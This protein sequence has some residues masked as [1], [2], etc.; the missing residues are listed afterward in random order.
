MKKNLLFFF[1]G[2]ILTLLVWLGLYGLLSKNSQN[3]FLIKNSII[4]YQIHSILDKYLPTPEPKKT[5]T[6]ILKAFTSSYWDQFT[7]YFWPDEVVSFQTMVSGDF[8][9]IW[10]YIEES[11]GG[12]Y[13]KWVIPNSPAQ[14]W[15]LLP[16]DV[17]Q[18]VD[19]TQLFN[20]SAEEAIKKIRWPAGS[21][22]VLEIFSTLLG[23]KKTVALIRNNIELPIIT[24]TLI[25]NV[26][27]IE[28]TSFN[29]HSSDDMKQV[30]KKNT[31]K[32]N[33]ILLDLRNNGGGTLQ[34]AV[35]VASIFIPKG[36]IVVSVEG[37]TIE[38]YR[39]YGE[40]ITTLPLTI[41]VNGETASAAEILASALHTHLRSSLVGSQTYGKWS[42]QEIFD[43]SNGGQIK[44][45]TSHWRTAAG[46]FL[47]G[48]GITPDTIILPTAQEVTEW[49]DG[50]R[51][52]AL[53]MIKK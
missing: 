13:I 40:N 10:A 20:V 1:T 9:G 27:V 25:G 8:D 36:K 2:I 21:E 35:D 17:I 48:V 22:V 19:D 37:K 14:L 7:T 44:V 32:Y 31:G 50:Q 4:S 5:E 45:T 18:K 28:L 41:L 34:A 51:I 52:R 39:S 30:L 16:G 38:Q 23:V 46:D 3:F 24:D 6:A 29:D 42:V 33:H 26:L 11:A 12:I 15:G 49:K 43:L 47:D 53:E